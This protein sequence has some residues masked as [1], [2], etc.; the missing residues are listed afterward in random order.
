[1]NPVSQAENGE[2]ENSDTSNLG[3]GH[4]DVPAPPV[5]IA[6]CV[7]GGT[8]AIGCMV[9]R[10]CHPNCTTVLDKYFITVLTQNFYIELLQRTRPSALARLPRNVDPQAAVPQQ[11]NI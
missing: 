6:P 11:L 9:V 8:S 5:F 3:I 4:S 2:Y 10:G 7:H 1:M